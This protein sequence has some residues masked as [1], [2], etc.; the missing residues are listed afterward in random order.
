M[1]HL[2]TI[3]IFCF[4]QLQPF[5]ASAQN[6]ELLKQLYSNQNQ[7]EKLET[8]H[9]LCKGYT[10]YSVDSFIKYINWGLSISD[11][12]SKEYLNFNYFKVYY[13]DDISQFEAAEKLTD[14][15]IDFC[16]NNKGN[17][18]VYCKILFEKS[19]FL[20]QK[21]DFNAALELHY[22][23][24]KLAEKTNDTSLIMDSY[25]SMG[26]MFMESNKY[27]EAIQW[28][29]KGIA[30]IKTQERQKKITNLYLNTASCY[31]NSGNPNRALELVNWGIENAKNL[32]KS[33]AL[34]N[35]LMIRSDIYINTKQLKK[36]KIDIEEAL[37]IREKTKDTFYIVSDL[38]QYSV[39]LASNGEYEKG[40]NTAKKGLKI[41]EKFNWL[42][43]KLYLYQ[44][45]AKNYKSTKKYEELSIIQDSIIKFTDSLQKQNYLKL[46]ADAAAKYETEKKELTIKN[47]DLDLRISKLYIWGL[48]FFLLLTL[49]IIYFVIRKLK[50]RQKRKLTNEIENERRRISNDL[51]DGV[52]AYASSLYTGINNLESDYH[53]KK[54]SNLKNTSIELIEKLN[55]TVWVLDMESITVRD[56]FD[57][58]KNWFL[59]IIPHFEGIDYE[60]EDNITYNKTLKPQDALDLLNMLQEMTNNALK[61]S[62]CSKI[63]CQITSDLS[64][65]NIEFSDNG[66]GL[67]LDKITKGNGLQNLEKRALRMNASIKFFSDLSGTKI[68]LKFI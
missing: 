59:K 12:K 64:V 19:N 6:P 31:N 18:W 20:F 67:D 40:I 26:W 28:F 49:L 38:A 57:K 60:F 3:F 63:Y 1:K 41:L 32:N 50:N 14:T 45:L 2:K 27:K 48:V 56:L 42:D 39:F 15:I 23:S 61:H 33:T 53:E 36:A 5:F 37:S 35:G 11:S 10:S 47:Q 30:L 54:V 7:K 16:E 62:G 17:N 9:K 52:G 8:L 13:Y 68:D 66:K 55:Q 43:K 46:T 25:L 24:I 34:A 22:K 29:E 65:F 44:A 4:F 21:G 58:Y 51:H